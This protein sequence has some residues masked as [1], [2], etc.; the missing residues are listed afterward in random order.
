MKISTSMSLLIAAVAILLLSGC[1]TVANPGPDRVQVDSD[2]SGATV[3]VD[4][5]PAG[6]TPTTVDLHRDNPG[7]IEIELE[8]YETKTIRKNQ[9]LNMWL[10]GNVCLTIWPAVI[11][12]ITSNHMQFDDRPVDVVLTPVEE[13]SVGVPGEPISLTLPPEARR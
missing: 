3:Y 10:I 5:Q 12:L 8:G 13:A 11:D 4:G 7:E 1:A 9:E 6:E 2:P